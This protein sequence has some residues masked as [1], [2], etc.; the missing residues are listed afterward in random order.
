MRDS[1]SI[2]RVFAKIVATT[3]L[4]RGREHDPCQQ[5]TFHTLRHTLGTCLAMTGYDLKTIQ[6]LMRHADIKD[7]LRYTNFAPGYCGQVIDELD[8]FRV[9][10]AH[11]PEA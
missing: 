5:V 1:A 7:T 4:N 2:G 6:K 8:S 3:E 9:V 11:A 10:P